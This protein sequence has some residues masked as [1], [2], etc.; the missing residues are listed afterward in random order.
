MDDLRVVGTLLAKPG[1]SADVTARGRDRLRAAA[2][3]PVRKRR[4]V[5]PL[6]ALAALA[7][8][9]AASTIV[10]VSDL[11]PTATPNG[12]PPGAAVSGRQ[13]LLAAATTA[14]ARPAGSGTYWHVKTV[15]G[16]MRSTESMESWTRRDG[17]EYWRDRNGRPRRFAGTT[18]FTIAGT[19]MGFTRI[20]RL[21]TDPAALKAEIT[22]LVDRERVPFRS[23]ITGIGREPLL[24][25]PLIDLLARIPAPPKVRAAAFRAIAGLPGV[26]RAGPTAGGQTLLIHSDDGDVR[27]VVDPA[28]SIV[29]GWTAT[30]PPVGKRGASWLADQSVSFPVAEWTS[31]LS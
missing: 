14:E 26:S 12:P 7:A 5:R 15:Y 21:P 31:R 2:R 10:V 1:P 8:A 9:A 19:G 25:Q 20:Q 18:A 22:R 4:F 28:T 13:I 27:L 24:V 17:R 6:T 16:D 11:A 30:A 23:R 3:V 29:R